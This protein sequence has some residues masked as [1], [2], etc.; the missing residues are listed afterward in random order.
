MKRKNITQPSLFDCKTEVYK[1]TFDE[2]F[3]ELK[4]VKPKR[5]DD[6][7][8]SS[9]P[10]SRATDADISKIL[11]QGTTTQ[12]ILK[13]NKDGIEADIGG[14]LKDCRNDLSGIPP[15]LD[16][17]I[18]EPHTAP[19]ESLPL[20]NIQNILLKIVTITN[21]GKEA[22]GVRVK[23]N[24]FCRKSAEF[25]DSEY[26]CFKIRFGHPKKPTHE[27]VE[28][29]KKLLKDYLLCTKFEFSSIGGRYQILAKTD[30]TKN[31]I[32]DVDG[33][34][35][36]IAGMPAESFVPYRWIYRI[37]MFEDKKLATSNLI[38][39]RIEFAINKAT[40]WAASE[41]VIEDNF[42]FDQS[43]KSY[44]KYDHGE[45]YGF[46]VTFKMIHDDWFE[47]RMRCFRE[48]IVV[49][50]KKH[51]MMSLEHVEVED[52]DEHCEY[53]QTRN[54]LKKTSVTVNVLLSASDTHATYGEVA[55]YYELL[56]DELG[57]ETMDDLYSDSAIDPPDF[58]EEM[59]RH[60][61]KHWIESKT[62]TVTR[63]LPGSMP[64]KKKW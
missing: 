57:M 30:F 26:Y 9:D 64:R 51:L 54:G 56:F 5:L 35:Q 20:H 62:E 59:T 28:T 43:D 58:P 42:A 24:Y 36:K 17:R 63:W 61:P 6:L 45:I 47:R 48:R 13:P 18:D 40:R 50:A 53:R 16:E 14:M 25:V 27:F 37:R 44:Y 11:Y 21:Y 7:F 55:E 23:D 22:F 8:D 34:Y 12:P 49:L 39:D 52:D 3:P 2:L 31:G 41:I 19:Y 1:E 46:Y 38:T 29:T 60:V 33:Y 32:P 15:D 4:G 10:D